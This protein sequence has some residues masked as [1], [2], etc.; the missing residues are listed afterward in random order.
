MLPGLLI[1]GFPSLVL[2]IIP[3]LLP[4][5]G[6][7]EKGRGKIAVVGFVKEYRCLEER[8]AAGAETAKGERRGS[9]YERTRVDI[10]SGHVVDA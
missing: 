7:G 2:S 9:A 1:R 5:T 4:E 8:S 3:V 10:F 6:K